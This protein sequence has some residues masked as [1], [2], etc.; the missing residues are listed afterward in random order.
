MFVLTRP[1]R[2]LYGDWFCC[3][4]IW[5]FDQWADSTALAFELAQP[6]VSW[7]FFPLMTLR[8]A[9]LIECGSDRHSRKVIVQLA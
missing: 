6:G 9:S 7:Q 8:N 1:A 4:K 3:C 2:S 5:I